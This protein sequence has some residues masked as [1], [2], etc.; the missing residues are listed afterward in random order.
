MKKHIIIRF[1]LSIL[2]FVFLSKMSFAIYEVK[3]EPYS[4]T[5][6]YCYDTED[7]LCPGDPIWF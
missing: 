1:L 2:A 3:R 4:L 5:F 6:D 7:P